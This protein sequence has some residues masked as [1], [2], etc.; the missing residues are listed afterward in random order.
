M[1]DGGGWST[2]HHSHFNPGKETWYTFYRRLGAPQVVCGLLFRDN[3]QFTCDVTHNIRNSQSCVQQNPHEVVW[4]NS[5]KGKVW[6]TRKSTSWTHLIEWCSTAACDRNLL[7]SDLVLFLVIDLLQQD[8]HCGYNNTASPR[9]GRVCGE[10]EQNLLKKMATQ[11]SI[12][13]MPIS[14][15][16]IVIVMLLPQG[17]HE[18]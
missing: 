16:Q 10:N 5:S 9:F 18:S 15:T 7:D 11:M 17:F 4:D 14:V 13:G 1:L 2:P 12:P 6:N 3:T 8:D